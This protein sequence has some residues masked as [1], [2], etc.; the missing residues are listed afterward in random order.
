MAVTAAAGVVEQTTAWT[1][2]QP[3]ER[4]PQ[5]V[6]NKNGCARTR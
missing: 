1:L 4:N 5:L 2:V 6:G 3:W